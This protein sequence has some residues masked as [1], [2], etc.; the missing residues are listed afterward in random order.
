M[1]IHD[2]MVSIGPNNNNNNGSDEGGI[3]QDE[4]QPKKEFG[5]IIFDHIKENEI[6]DDDE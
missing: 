1:N 2:S 4:M 5:S 6:E 3:D